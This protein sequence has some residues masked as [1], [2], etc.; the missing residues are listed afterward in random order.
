MCNGV[1][2][3]D[4]F[5]YGMGCVVGNCNIE[6]FVSYILKLS[7]EMKLIFGVIEKYMFEMC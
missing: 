2:F 3:F 4:L 5:V 6:L 1:I 7:Y